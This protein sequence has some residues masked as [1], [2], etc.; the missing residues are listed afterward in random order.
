MMACLVS[1][2]GTNLTNH[3][4]DVSHSFVV[5]VR[6]SVAV[7]TAGGAGEEQFAGMARLRAFP[8]TS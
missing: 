7:K 8:T 5:M 2:R 3:P 1:H 6:A 4:C